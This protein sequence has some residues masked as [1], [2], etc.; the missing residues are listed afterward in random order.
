MSERR[1]IDDLKDGFSLIFRAARG[2]AKDIQP[3]KVDHAMNTGAK[4]LV[5]VINT[6]GRA[7]GAELEKNFGGQDQPPKRGSAPPPA[8]GPPP[9]APRATAQ[10]PAKDAPKD[11]ASGGMGPGPDGG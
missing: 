10:E 4:E 3:D 7:L 6:V 5:R 11:R 8:G 2:M 1:P 9:D